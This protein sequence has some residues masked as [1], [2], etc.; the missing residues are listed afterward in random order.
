[1]LPSIRYRFIGHLLVQPLTLPSEI[2][3]D[4]FVWRNAGKQHHLAGGIP[5]RVKHVDLQILGHFP[6]FSFV[7]RVA[8]RKKP[9]G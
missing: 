2:C 7:C 8:V 1:M 9:T 4:Q 3:A 6:F 5:R